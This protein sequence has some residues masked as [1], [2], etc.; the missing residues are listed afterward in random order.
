MVYGSVLVRSSRLVSWLLPLTMSMALGACNHKP[1]SRMKVAVTI[2]PIYDLARRIAGRD[3]DVVLLVPVGRSE[4]DFVPSSRETQTATGTKLGIMVGLGLDD[5]M[6]GLLDGAAPESRRLAVGDRVPTLA[7][8]PNPIALALQGLPETGAHLDAKPDPHVWLDPSRAALL[9]KAIA[10]EMARTDPPRAAGY[11][12]RSAELMQD[13]E[14]LDHEVELR[15]ATWRS[16][17]FVPLRPAFAYFAER[18]HLE[19]PAVLEASAGVAP[20]ARYEQEVVKVLRAQGVPGVFREPQLAPDVASFVGEAAGVP[21]G[22]LDA[23][24][25][26]EQTDT[27]DRLIR[28]DTAALESL[29]LAPQGSTE[30]STTL[31]EGGSAHDAGGD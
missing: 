7:Y 2:F 28:F 18:Y 15:V 24:G 27:Y 20:S 6:Q 22:V 17:S 23:L 10:E 1:A 5:W 19:I 26:G 13:L 3:A 14:G 11:R 12:Q 25:G 9:T 29:L 16:R 8:R 21:V 31:D 4:V 30:G